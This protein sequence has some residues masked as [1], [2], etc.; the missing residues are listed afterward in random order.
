MLLNKHNF[1]VASFASK[2]ESRY[3]LKGIMVNE[4][5][6]VATNGH[7]LVMVGLPKAKESAFPVIEGFTP[8]NGSFKP[9]IL[10]RDAALDIAKQIPKN[11]SLSILQ[12][13]IVGVAEGSNNSIAVTDLDRAK[14]FKTRNLEGSFP[15][16]E[17]VLP[18]EHAT[19]TITVDAEYLAELAKAAAQFQDDKSTTRAVTLR[20]RG[21][22]TAVEMTAQNA[23]T[24]QKWSALL[25]PTRV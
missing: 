9:F 8:A 3:T 7:Y 17:A 4:Q 11:Q 18:K 25:M 13:A 19:L 23:D 10:Q 6:A 22:N 12:N 16:Y 2:D 21:P 15:N 1:A 5:G 24:E 20:F 14:I